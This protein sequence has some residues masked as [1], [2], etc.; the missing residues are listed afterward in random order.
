MDLT[1]KEIA[2]NDIRDNVDYL[3][4]HEYKDNISWIL[5]YIVSD[6]KAKLIHSGEDRYTLDYMKR[7]YQLP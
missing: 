1:L 7:V 3:F 4:M 5:G 2:R 6:D